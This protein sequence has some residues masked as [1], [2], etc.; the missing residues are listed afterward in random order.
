VKLLALLIA[1][2]APRGRGLTKIKGQQTCHC[3]SSLKSGAQTMADSSAPTSCARMK[4][5]TWSMAIN[6][7]SEKG[8]EGN[9]LGGL[10]AEG[11]EALAQQ[12][13]G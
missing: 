13:L 1:P 10:A 11:I 4:P 9:V 12:G 2:N 7:P 8:N 3:F 6:S 5:G